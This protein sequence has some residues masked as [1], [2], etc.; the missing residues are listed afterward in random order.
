M[1][2]YT[3]SNRNISESLID[4]V[5]TNSPVKVKICCQE[6]KRASDHQLVWI[7]RSSKNH[8]EKVNKTEKRCMR[9]FNMEDLEM[10]CQQED[11]T[12]KGS[13]ERTEEA[14]EERVM[15]LERKICNILEKVAP[16]EVK[17]MEYRGKP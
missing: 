7:E 1:T 6:K 10:L 4:L 8:V 16:M 12:H 11:L 15:N 5:W 14:L 3:N 9:M 2:H 17:P 13:Q